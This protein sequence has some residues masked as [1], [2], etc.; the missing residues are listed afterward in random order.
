MRLAVAIECIGEQDGPTTGVQPACIE[1]LPTK[2]YVQDR[3]L[4]IGGAT[5]ALD[6]LSDPEVEPKELATVRPAYT[7]QVS[8]CRF[9]PEDC[10]SLERPRTNAIT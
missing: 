7:I 3:G 6:G 8:G 9:E 4:V 1:V 10:T 2:D 5:S